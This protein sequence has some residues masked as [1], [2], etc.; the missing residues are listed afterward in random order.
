M[1]HELRKIKRYQIV[2]DTFISI[3][4]IGT[5]C[6][7]YLLVFILNGNRNPKNILYMEIKFSIFSKNMN[8]LKIIMYLLSLMT[9]GSVAF[10]YNTL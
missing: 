2:I 5:F 10:V 6:I 3:N 9:V 7:H 4:R 8:K 1:S